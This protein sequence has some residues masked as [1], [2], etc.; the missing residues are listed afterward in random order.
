MFV[1]L[2][3]IYTEMTKNVAPPSAYSFFYFRSLSLFL[4]LCC[5]CRFYWPIFSLCCRYCCCCI[6]CGDCCVPLYRGVYIFAWVKKCD[7]DCIQTWRALAQQFEWW[8]KLNRTHNIHY[9]GNVYRREAFA[10]FFSFGCILLPLDF[11]F[12][13]LFAYR[14]SYCIF[15]S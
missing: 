4:Y 5:C 6:H 7:S 12:S 9:D 2:Y 10:L 14:F 3:T 1:R 11:P 8:Y 13:S 15:I